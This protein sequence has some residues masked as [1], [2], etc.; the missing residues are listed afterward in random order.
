MQHWW[1]GSTRDVARPAHRHCTGSGRLAT[2]VWQPASAQLE[3]CMLHYHPLLKKNL[4]RTGVTPATPARLC[5]IFLEGGA[6]IRRI[7]WFLGPT[8]KSRSRATSAG[9]ASSISLS[10]SLS[11]T[12]MTTLLCTLPPHT[13]SDHDNFIDKAFKCCKFA[14]LSTRK[15][16]LCL[17]Y[18]MRRI[19]AERHY[20]VLSYSVS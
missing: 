2:L 11:K 1:G 3:C 18:K 9:W 14:A 20:R 19:L 7:L 4:T 8:A 6:T 17:A 13:T 15:R 5:R 16:C 10:L 12:E